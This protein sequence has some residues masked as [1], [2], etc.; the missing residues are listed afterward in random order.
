M[1]YF[2]GN[3]NEENNTVII[4]NEEA[5][6]CSVVL[7]LRVGEII[8][9]LNQNGSIFNIELTSVH[10]KQCIGKIISV[11]KYSPPNIHLHLVVS[12]PKNNERLEWLV[13]KAV[14]L[15]VNSILFVKS[16]R[17]I[18][19]SIN[20]KRLSEI[21][22]AAAKQS[23]NPYS[24]QINQHLTLNNLLNTLSTSHTEYLLLHCESSSEK[25]PLTPSFIQQ[26]QQR[27]VSNIFSFIGPEGDWTLDEIKTIKSSLANVHEISLGE[28]RLR[29]ET[30]AIAIISMLSILR[31]N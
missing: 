9:V 24:I 13:E 31:N 15:Q 2:F 25:I 21:A 29:T 27:Q 17:S 11:K 1:H 22:K 7:R 12:P 16:E 23:I 5:H 8:G 14:E 18:R 30:A 28:H 19:K 4:E 3:I 20:I 6:H 10:K 26:L